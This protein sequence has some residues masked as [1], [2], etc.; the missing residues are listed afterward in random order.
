MRS[1]NS[2]WR[3]LVMTNANH[4][5]VY[6]SIGAPE[7]LVEAQLP[8]PIPKTGEVLLKV[9]ASGFNP[10]DTKI[11]AGLAPIASDNHVPG[12]D[13]CGEVVALGEGVSKFVVGDIVYGCA[14]GVKGSS[15]TLCKYMS[16]DVDLLARK[17]EPLTSAQ[18]SILPLISIT[19]FEAL[20]R[21][22]VRVGDELLIMGGTGGVGQMAIQLAKLKGASVTAT[23]GSKEGLRFIES[24]G[25]K[26]VLHGKTNEASASFNKVLDTH[27]GESFQNALLAA[28]PAAQV[29]T[30]NARNTYDLAQAHAKALTIHAVFMLLPLIAGNGRKTH[31]DFLVWLAGEI[32]SGSIK[33]P[34]MQE[35]MPSEIAEIHRCYE[36]GD[37]KVKT[38]F[39]FS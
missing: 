8:M 18:A 19:A 7:E 3:S 1:S 11:R 36:A 34:V 9:Q 24:L 31:G 13:V 27:G 6:P 4:G 30:I 14:G 20:E 15:G 29:A 33:A 38:A 17:P 21:L 37:L 12:C 28:A 22:N 25:A 2:Y 23:A 39:V 16:A 10:I 26:A 32:E 35:K 5:W